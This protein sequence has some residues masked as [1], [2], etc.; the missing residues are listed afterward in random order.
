MYILLHKLEQTVKEG[1]L[2]Y[3]VN[4]TIWKA[5]IFYNFN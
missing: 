4:H 3:I 1:T 5:L 2:K